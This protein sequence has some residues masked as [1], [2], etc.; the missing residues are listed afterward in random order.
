MSATFNIELF[1][2]YFSK[3]SISQIEQKAVYVGIEEKMRKD[4]EDK[5]DK[6]ALAWGPCKNEN[7][8]N[9]NGGQSVHGGGQDDDDQW[10]DDHQM[11]VKNVMPVEKMNDP[12]DV[13]EINFRLFQVE[14]LYVDQIVDSLL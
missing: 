10:T 11:Q 13:I 6:L 5:K 12:A 9:D 4:E 3:L 7:Q 2:N 8:W 1:A 14:E